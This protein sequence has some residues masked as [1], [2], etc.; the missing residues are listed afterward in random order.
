MHHCQYYKGFLDF[1]TDWVAQQCSEEL[2]KK[3][4]VILAMIYVNFFFKYTLGGYFASKD[5][6][7]TLEY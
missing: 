3:P 1:V 4:I 6:S 2:E 7:C 5:S